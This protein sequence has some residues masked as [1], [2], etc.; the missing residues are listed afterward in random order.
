MCC[1]SYENDYYAE[2]IKKMPKIGSEVQT[3][4]GKAIVA[5]INML[6]MEVKV[7]I[8]DRNGGWIWKDYPAEDIRFK[9]NNQPEKEDKDDDIDVLM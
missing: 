5:G 9:K 1:L 3:P 2:A 6:K 8:D 4:E 7:K